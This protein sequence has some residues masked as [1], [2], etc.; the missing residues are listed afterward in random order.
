M[1]KG[2]GFDINSLPLAGL[3]ALSD[4]GRGLLIRAD[5]DSVSYQRTSTGSVLRRIKHLK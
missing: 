5:M 3:D 4:R 2:R 1:T